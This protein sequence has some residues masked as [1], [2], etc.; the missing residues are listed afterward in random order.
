MAIDEN[1]IKQQIDDYEYTLQTIVALSGI[2][3]YDFAGENTQGKELKTSSSN[4]ISPSTIVTPDLVTEVKIPSTSKK[5]GIISEIKVD[6]PKNKSFWMKDVEQLKKY[7]D[8]L[9]G[10]NQDHKLDHDLMFVSNPLRTYDFNEYLNST[11]VI[12]KHKFRR[13]VIVVQSSRMQQVNAFILIKKE[14]GTFTIDDMDKMMTRGIGV[15]QIRILPEV[16]KMKFYDSKPPIIYTMMIIWDHILKTNLTIDQLRDMER[17]R[18]IDIRISVDDILDKLSRFA[19]KTNKHCI[20]RDWIIESMNA[21]SDLK[22]ATLE[23]ADTQLYSIKL[24]IHGGDTRNWLISKFKEL[25]EKKS[26][27]LDKYM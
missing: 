23:N 12:S 16:T 6:L 1:E 11:P 14:N 5:L 13:N 22:L 25:E 15:P 2:F 3:E 17:K 19:P 21:F 20:R 24:S 8:E 4:T 9:V 27:T 10:W 18:H 7:D 26:Q